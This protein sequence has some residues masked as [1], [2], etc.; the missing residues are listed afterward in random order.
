MVEY[1][2]LPMAA[3]NEEAMSDAVAHKAFEKFVRLERELTTLLQQ[4]LQQ[5]QEMLQ[6]MPRPGG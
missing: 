3:H 5:D 1:R 6:Q 4:Q 2:N